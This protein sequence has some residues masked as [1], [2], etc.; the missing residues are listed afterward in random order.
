MTAYTSQELAGMSMT[1]KTFPETVFIDY[2]YFYFSGALAVKFEYS[3]DF[4]DVTTLIM[5]NEIKSYAGEIKGTMI[6]FADMDLTLRTFIFIDYIRPDKDQLSLFKLGNGDPKLVMP[7][8]RVAMV[9][10]P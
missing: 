7:S 8:S 2:K 4:L 6:S 3:N 1:M 9:G 5:I 10:T